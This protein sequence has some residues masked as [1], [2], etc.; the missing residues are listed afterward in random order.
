MYL[1]LI[2][3]LV[4]VRCCFFKYW[5][6]YRNTIAPEISLYDARILYQWNIA[7]DSGSIRTKVDPTSDVCVTWT[8]RSMNGKWVTDVRLPLTGT[9]LSALAA[10]VK[11]RRQFNF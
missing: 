6:V 10:D 3:K 1:N 4:F 9:T 7:L 8:D 2:S 11:V 5:R